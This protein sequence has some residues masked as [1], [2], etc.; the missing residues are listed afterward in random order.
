[1]GFPCNELSKKFFYNFYTFVCLYSVVLAFSYWFH[2]ICTFC[3]Y[4]FHFRLLWFFCMLQFDY[5]ILMHSATIL[6]SCSLYYVCLPNW[7]KFLLVL[8]FIV[9]FL[10][11]F[12]FI[13]KKLLD[14][15]FSDKRYCR[16]DGSQ[17]LPVRVTIYEP[18]RPSFISTALSL[19]WLKIVYDFV[20]YILLMNF[21]GVGQ[22][23]YYKSLKMSHMNLA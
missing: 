9:V 16:N 4:F 5:F 10:L 1:M 23:L 7:L 12:V 22:H 6:H 21:V 19:Y 17:M 11:A 15:L 8:K 3:C 18:K 13:Q 20:W 14:F 2:C